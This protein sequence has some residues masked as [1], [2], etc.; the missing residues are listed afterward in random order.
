MWR[1]DRDR[2]DDPTTRERETQRLSRDEYERPRYDAPL[3]GSERTTAIGETQ[4]PAGFDDA[5]VQRLS[6]SG[7]IQRRETEPQLARGASP[8]AASA[9]VQT[10]TR[11]SDLDSIKVSQIMTRRVTSVRPTT[12]VDRAARLMEEQDCGA[13]PV[14]GNNGMLVGIVTDRDIALR[15]VARGRDARQALVTD[16]MTDRV[17]AC[18]AHESIAECMRQMAEHRVRR[19][20]IVDEEGRVVGIV[21][22]SDLA[23]HALYHPVPEEHHALTEVVGKVSQPGVMPRR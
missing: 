22:Q 21:A 1:K 17:I 3:A 16:C 5:R 15:V 14:V 7:Y 19:L 6:S 11:R 23:R 13:V 10:P 2:P 18:Y 12:P 9:D 4:Q 20:P 8:G